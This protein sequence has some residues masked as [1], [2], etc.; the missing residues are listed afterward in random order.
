M[1]LENHPASFDMVGR[2]ATPDDG[3]PATWTFEGADY[4]LTPNGEGWD[5]TIDGRLLGRLET[6]NAAET[7]APLHWR[8]R[9]PRHDGLGIGSTWGNWQDAVITLIDYRRARE[10]D[11]S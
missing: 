4:R 9:D 6:D 10:D 11:R 2:T 5:V 7:P 1:A 3:P 8:I